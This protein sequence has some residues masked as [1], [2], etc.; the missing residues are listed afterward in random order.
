MIRSLLCTLITAAVSFATVPSVNVAWL[1]VT[2]AERQMKAPVVD[3]NAGVE[4]LFWRVYVVDDVSGQDAQRI[5]YHYVR[6]KIF[7]P[8]GKEKAA[9]IDLQ[10]GDKAAINSIVGR[11]IK[12]DGTI[13]ELSKDAIHERVLVR[14]GGIKRKVVSFAMPGVEVGSIVEY[15]WRERISQS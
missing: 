6:L 14:A 9:T 5:L 4:A 8:E 11:T 3:K 13:V 15:R 10:Y 12:P 7:T 2:D 1:P